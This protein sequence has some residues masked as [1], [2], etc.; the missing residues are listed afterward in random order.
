ME[1]ENRN[2]KR[3]K[4]MEENKNQYTEQEIRNISENFFNMLLSKNVK[5]EETRQTVFRQTQAEYE[6][7]KN[8]AHAHRMNISEYLRFLVEM[9]R[10][11]MNNAKK[12]A[13][14]DRN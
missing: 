2:I 10:E 14:T 5:K 6:K 4:Y 13:N 9:E 3:R 8:D 7:L 11:R 1:S 12:N